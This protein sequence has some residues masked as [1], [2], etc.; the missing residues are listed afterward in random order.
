MNNRKALIVFLIAGILLSSSALLYAQKIQY[1]ADRMSKKRG[2]S[3]I[4]LRNNV[5]LSQGDM[6]IY[7]REA[8][9]SSKR[10]AFKARGNVRV[11][12][13]PSMTIF[14]ETLDYDGKTRK[15]KFRK[16]VRL[17]DD[18]DTLYTD[19][20]DFNSSDNSGYFYNGGKIID[21]TATLESLTGY[22]YPDESSYFFQD[23]VR[24]RNDK[25][26]LKSD[27]LR[28]NKINQKAYVTGP[29]E[30]IGDSSYI[31]CEDG[32]YDMRNDIARIKKNALVRRNNRVLTGDSLYFEQEK[33]FGRGFS[34]VTVWDTDEQLLLKGN[35]GEYYDE[36]RRAMMTDSALFI[37]A[38]NPQDSVFLHADTLRLHYDSTQS[39]EIVRAYY[40]AQIFK[41]DVQARSDS[42]TYASADSVFRF[43]HNPVIWSDSNQITANFIALHTKGQELDYVDL[44]G[45]PMIVAFE[46]DNRYNQLKGSK[47]KGY[48]R[49]NELYRLDAEEAA[50]SVYYVRDDKQLIGVNVAQCD[51]MS[52]FLKEQKVTRV[53]FL[54]KPDG[55]LFPMHQI[56][57]SKKFLK[58]F[59]WLAALRPNNKYDI[60]T[61][62]QKLSTI[63]K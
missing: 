12:Q 9:F 50:Q 28:Y 58:G 10:N 42:I 57:E 6:V 37:D 3:T 15:G 21:S 40:H 39:N 1:S 63:E 20:L 7:S 51:R 49:N 31:Y 4:L 53:K 52:I 17:I 46:G 43:Y 34:N 48:F 33:G 36:P 55:I 19:Y 38:S 30:I 35:Y 45:D 16:N 54:S 60:F 25:Y 13:G 62:E 59:Q 47:M 44:Q 27:S 61:W 2:S 5:R 14:S 18:G 11:T 8:D 23:S 26:L 32:W 56:P 22:Y 24:L 41:N 29:T